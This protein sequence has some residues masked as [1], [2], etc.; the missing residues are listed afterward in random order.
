MARYL[1]NFGSSLQKL[2][3]T[4]SIVKIAPFHKNLVAMI[5]Q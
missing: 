5:S 2:K 1:V 3:N 4:Y